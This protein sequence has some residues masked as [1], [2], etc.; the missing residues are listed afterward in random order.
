MA[1]QVAGLTELF[2]NIAETPETPG[3]TGTRAVGARAI[4]AAGGLS[5]DEGSR[6]SNESTN[7]GDVNA[8][9]FAVAVKRSV[10]G[11]RK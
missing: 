11:R 5:E 8:R 6:E 1:V 4:G 10:S 7:A 3:P 9:A 2:I